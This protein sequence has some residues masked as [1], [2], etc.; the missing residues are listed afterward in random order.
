MHLIVLSGNFMVARARLK[1]VPLLASKR[2][3]GAYIIRN[4]LD[5]DTLFPAFSDG[6]YYFTKSMHFKGKTNLFL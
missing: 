2:I 1:L 5:R 4:R 6:G 3:K